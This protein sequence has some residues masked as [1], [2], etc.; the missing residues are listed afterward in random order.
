MPSLKPIKPQVVAK[1]LKFALRVARRYR[2]QAHFVFDMDSTLF[3]MR[4]RTQ[5]IIR[6]CLKE[7]GFCKTFAKH[8]DLIKT[9][10]VKTQ[11][12]SV[13]EVFACKDFSSKHPLVREV[14]GLWRKKFFSGDFLNKDLPYKGATR[15]CRQIA[16][17]GSKLCY[18]TA[19]NQTKMLE[20][21]VKSLNFFNFPYKNPGD[22][23]MKKDSSQEDA[24]YKVM[25][26][27]KLKKTAQVVLFFENEPVIL[28]K[29]ARLLPEIKLFWVHSTHSGRQIPPKTARTV[30]INYNTGF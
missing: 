3:C 16:F 17:L 23:I 30:S 28:N 14:A 12:W 11:N 5:A 10:P 24:A 2:K 26:L 18:L 9:I 20:G 13:E 21:T 1:N 15:F 22:L 8:L 27:K 6:D 4:Y 7:P 19:R 25:E 29:V